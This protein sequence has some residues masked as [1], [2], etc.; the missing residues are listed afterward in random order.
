[1]ETQK[2][3]MKGVV[4]GGILKVDVPAKLKKAKREL[5]YCTDEKRKQELEVMI[6]V[7]TDFLKKQEDALIR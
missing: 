7:F 3:Q 5:Q 2:G 6:A 4:L 1:M